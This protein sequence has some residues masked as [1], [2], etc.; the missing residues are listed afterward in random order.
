MFGSNEEILEE[1]DSTLNQL[2]TNVRTFEK[3]AVSDLSEDEIYAIQCTQ[4]SLMARFIHMNELIKDKDRKKIENKKNSELNA[5]Y[6][7]LEAFSQVNS[8]LYK[9]V[10]SSLNT[11]GPLVKKKPRIGKNRKRLKIG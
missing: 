9:K 6:V 3:V 11:T 8:T 4:E 2:I 10:S 7:K 1:L 5:L